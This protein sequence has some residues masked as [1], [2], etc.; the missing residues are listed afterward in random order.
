[1]GRGATLEGGVSDRVGIGTVHQRLALHEC[2][3]MQ[4]FKNLIQ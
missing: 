1:M 2:L 3:G 4:W